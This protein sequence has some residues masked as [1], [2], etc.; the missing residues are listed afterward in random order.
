MISKDPQVTYLDTGPDA[1][2]L[3]PD[4]ITREVEKEAVSWVSS[5]RCPARLCPLGGDICVLINKYIFW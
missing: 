5:S 2:K 4:Y 3:F 1:V